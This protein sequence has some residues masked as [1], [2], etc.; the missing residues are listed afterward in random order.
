MAAVLEMLT[1]VDHP[2]GTLIAWETWGEAGSS[3]G[4]DPP[5]GVKAASDANIANAISAIFVFFMKNSFSKSH[6]FIRYVLS[7]QARESRPHARKVKI[8][9]K[10]F[11]D[12]DIFEESG[13]GSSRRIKHPAVPEIECNKDSLPGGNS[14][15]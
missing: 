12:F 10:S 8:R 1:G 14:I 15:A 13:N 2:V 9:K 6:Y 7:G 4:F 11:D 5:A 3:G